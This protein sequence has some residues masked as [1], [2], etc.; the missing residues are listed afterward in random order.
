LRVDVHLYP[1][2]IYDKNLAEEV[3]CPV[4]GLGQGRRK[5]KFRLKPNVPDCFAGS[6]LNESNKSCAMIYGKG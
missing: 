2:I 4:V 6:I 5:T 3:K 1:H